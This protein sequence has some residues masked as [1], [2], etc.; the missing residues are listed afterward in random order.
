MPPLCTA[1]TL[2]GVAVTVGVLVND[3]EGVDS[4]V[5]SDG[6]TAG[7]PCPSTADRLRAEG[8]GLYHPFANA[9]SDTVRLVYA[10]LFALVPC[11]LLSTPPLGCAE[12]GVSY[13]GMAPLAS[14]AVYAPL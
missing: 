11:G 10:L 4:P 14:Y 12:P 3:T 5:S 7:L 13:E 9:F 8:V 2:D 6:A 1:P